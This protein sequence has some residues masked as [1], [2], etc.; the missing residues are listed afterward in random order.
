MVA[1][2]KLTATA[3][4]K[5]FSDLL[6]RV[7]AGETIEIERH[8]HTVAVI[9]PPQ[10]GLISGHDLA[11]LANRLP[12]PDDDFGCDTARLGE[13]IRPAEPWPS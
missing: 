1:I 5:E 13:V 10:R 4:S 11:A 7:V 2:V 6:S 8:G 3:A 12:V 9:V